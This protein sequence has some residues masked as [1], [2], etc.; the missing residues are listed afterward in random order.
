[1][2]QVVEVMGSLTAKMHARADADV[3]QG[4]LSYHSEK[5][6]A[7]AMGPDPDAF[8]RYISQWAYGYATQVEKDFVM[9]TEWVKER[10]GEEAEVP[11]A[12]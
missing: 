12:E 8:A 3:D 6:I 4:I 7:K 11:Q 9:F 1:M 2:L 10:F 5:E